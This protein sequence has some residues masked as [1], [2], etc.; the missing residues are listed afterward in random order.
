MS[1]GNDRQRREREDPSMGQTKRTIRSDLLRSSI[2]A[3]ATLIAMTCLHAAGAES[4]APG[5]ALPRIEVSPNG[6]FLITEN[7]KPFFWLGDTGWW[8]TGISPADVDV[9]LANVYGFFVPPSP[10][11]VQKLPGGPGNR[12]SWKT[13]LD[14]PGGAQLVHLR[15]LTESQPF[16][17]QVPDPSLFSSP[18]NTGN[19]HIGVLR[20][21]GYAMVYTPLGR[22]F[23]VRLDRLNWREAALTWFDPRSG[24]RA[25]AGKVAATGVHQFDPPSDPGDGNDWVLVLE[26]R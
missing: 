17:N 7:G 16:L 25:P 4:R 20:G 26:R 19:G 13:A 1:S 9:Y 6:R 11:F 5:R 8:M 2:A 22:S 21:D 15:A 14:A 10:G 24:R 3:A 18:P 12:E 23:S